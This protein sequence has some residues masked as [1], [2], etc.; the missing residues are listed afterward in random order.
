VS[1]VESLER[2]RELAAIESSLA[3]VQDGEGKLLFVEAQAGVGKSQLLATAVE[4]G[5]SA[6]MR[7]LTAQGSAFEREHSFGVAM[8]LLELSIAR[9]SQP[10]RDELLAG[11]A[12]LARPIL[13]HQEAPSASVE[14]QIFA[15]LRG[16]YRLTLNLAQNSPLIVAA[17][18]AHWTDAPSL[19]FLLYLA[20]RLR[21]LPVLLITSARPSE[22]G[23]PGQLL[24][25][26][27][28]HA[29]SQVLRPEAL[30]ANA[31]HA[32]V[33]RQFSGAEV[34][35]VRV[36]GDVTGGNPYL[37]RE[38]LADLKERGVGPT[39]AS[40]ELV[41]HAAPASIRDAVLLRLGRL[42]DAS[43][44]VARA[45]A[46]LGEH[47]TLRNVT[48]LAGLD[49]TVA[50]WAIDALVAAD[51]LA[52]R[53]RS[54]LAF[55]Q[56]I[57]RSAIYEVILTA[58]RGD[59]HCRA[60]RLL[61]DAGV[62]VEKVA[63][64]LAVAPSL[65]DAWVVERLRCAA[66]GALANG[67]PGSA[68]AYLDRAL[69][70]PPDPEVRGKVLVE[71]GRAGARAGK[72]EALARLREALVVT[73]ERERR[74]EIL[75]EL[76][77]A[78]HKSGEMSGAVDAI[79]R[80]LAEVADYQNE[81][82]SRLQVAYLQL[83]RLIP[84]RNDSAH[85]E[86]VRRL[87]VDALDAAGKQVKPHV[88][89]LLSVM[90]M[91]VVCEGQNHREAVELSMKAWDG[92]R[93]LAQEGSDNPTMWHVI[94]CLNWADDL[95]SAEELLGAAVGSAER[96]GSIVTVALG[97][98]ARA[99]PGYWRGRL[100]AAEAD[101][102][103]AVLAWR[104][105]YAM[106]LPAAAYLLALIRLELGDRAGAE[107]ALELPGVD[108]WTD[109]LLYPPYLAG[110]GL[111]AI[112]NGE[113][114]EAVRLLAAVGERMH[115]AGVMNPAVLPWRSYLSA[116][117]L[118]AGDRRRAR[119]VAAEEV[120]LARHFGAARPIGVAL[121]AAGLAEGGE[122]GIT[123]LTEA[124]K[125]LRRSPSKLE[126]V[127]ALIEMGASI[128]RHGRRVEARGPLREALAIAERSEAAMLAKR[129]REE[130]VA[131][132]AKPRRHC[133]TGVTSLTPSERRVAEMAAA[134]MR[135]REIAQQLVVSIKT[136]QY[137]LGNVYR[138]L[139]VPDRDALA[140]VLRSADS[141]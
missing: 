92:G 88:R 109:S 93:L 18:D 106:Y 122:H 53:P 8:Q 49:A 100:Y 42:P 44:A 39:A 65:G 55:V 50:G 82:R 102:Q 35:F 34:E 29:A 23:A 101:A 97:S 116:A 41:A 91:Q 59:M 38:L 32:L 6:G 11:A 51:L 64:H 27:K 111:L 30:T 117:L 37:L 90:A 137:H 120:E 19:R 133:V 31:V 80:G 24:R 99:W 15:H 127:R 40:A 95:D 26:L 119:A 14:N 71:L 43:S 103:A 48:L 94:A 135:N 45:V 12:A 126:L 138:K 69:D 132:G 108:R 68:W 56:P 75:L 83:S 36:C 84:S 47:A 7:V 73:Q 105:E 107:Q 54:V 9:A 86:Q 10:K 136:V 96:A 98:Y 76:G 141:S 104:G 89:S 52:P 4:R 22:P 62:S 128:R 113:Y 67:S 20:Q 125:T 17:D 114:A 66:D 123:L 78:L 110:R 58:E 60:A 1:E 2:E 13:E 21:D 118:G 79:E 25:E 140:H 16:L 3:S 131:A 57:V 112:S 124:V 129:A 46:V 61:D 85:L 28:L 70:E 115:G 130:L 72:G 121:R 81:L 87:P 139:S 63:A 5:R 74:G 33:M 134:G 77:W